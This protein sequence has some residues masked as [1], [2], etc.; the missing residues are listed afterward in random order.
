LCIIFGIEQE[1]K[2]EEKYEGFGKSK[3]HVERCMVQWR[4]VPLEECPHHFIHTLS[5]IQKKWYKE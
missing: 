4:V 1:H 3:E 5:G 2:Y